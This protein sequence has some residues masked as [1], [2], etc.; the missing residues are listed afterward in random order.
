MRLAFFNATGTLFVP[1]YEVQFGVF[2]SALNNEDLVAFCRNRNHPFKDCLVPKLVYDYIEQLDDINIPIHVIHR[3][4]DNNV[5]NLLLNWLL[6]AYAPHL[7]RHNI[8]FVG[9]IE[10]KFDLILTMQRN[11]QFIAQDV[12]FMDS[13]FNTVIT[14]SDKGLNAHH[15]SEILLQGGCK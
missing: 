12:Y 15:T 1:K 7:N 8:H 3:E 10:E 5:R 9:T 11:N 4:T 6:E 13:D 2:K 14:A